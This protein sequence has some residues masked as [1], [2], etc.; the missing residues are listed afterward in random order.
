MIIDPVLQ[1]SVWSS[2]VIYGLFRIGPVLAGTCRI[3]ADSC[4]FL[5]IFMDLYGSL[6][7]FTELYGSG[8]GRR[9]AIV[10]GTEVPS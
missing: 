8:L 3:L 1:S 2:I 5:R 6:R 10:F 7:I 9:Q 4:G